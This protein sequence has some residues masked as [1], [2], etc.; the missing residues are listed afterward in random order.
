MSGSLRVPFEEAVSEKLLLKKRFDELS[1]PQQTILLA[2]YGCPLPTEEHKLAWAV[3]QESCDY[4]ELGY[5][6]NV[7]PFPY[8]PREYRQLYACC[9]RRGGKTDTI[10]ATLL[11]YEATL[12]GHQE[13]IRPG[14]ECFL[15]GIAHRLDNAKANMAFVR[16][17]L[18]S[19]PLLSKEIGTVTAESIRLKNGLTIL[20]STAN[21][22]AQRGFA[23]PGLYMDEIGFWYSD[24]DAA[25]P[26][27]EVVRAVA[28]SQLQFPHWT[29]VA[30][31][32]P[33]TK[34]GLLWKYR[35]AGTMGCRL[36]AGVSRTE[37][38]DTLV[39][40]ATTAAMQ[41]PRIT[42]KA[43][44]QLKSEDP[45]AFSRES[46]CVFPDAISGFF[47]A[48]A[49]FACVERGVGE[50]PKLPREGHPEDSKP[51]YVCAIDPA[52]RF[53]SFAFCVAHRDAVKG[54]IVDAVRRW[55]PL[56]NQALNPRAVLAEMIPI[57]RYYGINSIYSDQYHLESLQQLALDL[58]ISIE[59]VDFTSK[60]KSKIY[61]NLQQLVNQNNLV[62]LDPDRS[63]PARF[64]LEELLRLERRI[65]S[66]G[67]ISIAAPEGRHDDMAAVLA[68]AAFQATWLMPELPHNQEFNAPRTVFEECMDQINRKRAEREYGS[69]I[70][71]NW[72]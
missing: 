51:H 65:L 64:M 48:N 6:L 45:D 5:P 43:L 1:I 57:L 31:S 9:G 33:W 11:A 61:G 32:S 72:D 17:T 34:E 62:L 20:P 39:V 66:G 50:R 28:Y 63:E 71:S 8:V 23:V 16:A 2:F 37:F 55:T 69:S 36:P 12:A 10:G 14:Q 68:L 35:M 27:T 25:N 4:D 52:F 49:L 38:E 24:P 3:F 56:R 41:N 70:F 7:R 18:E 29:R 60:S 26:D 40:F 19:S 22:R 67:T 53:D 47:A 21:L 59:G 58:G 13:Y 54:V 44:A 15:Y 30:I 46:L 42:R